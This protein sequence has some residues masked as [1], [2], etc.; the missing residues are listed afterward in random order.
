MIGN[1]NVI[2]NEGYRALIREL[3]TAGTVVFLRQFENGSGNYTEER[4]MMLNE[5][6]IDDIAERIKKRNAQNMNKL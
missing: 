4:Q 2:R 3:G 1:L 6:S 5:N